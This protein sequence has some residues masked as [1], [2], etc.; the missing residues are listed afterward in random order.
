M[1]LRGVTNYGTG[2]SAHELT[3]EGDTFFR[4][5]ASIIGD[6][7]AFAYPGIPGH[8]R[9]QG[10]RFGNLYGNSRVGATAISHLERSPERLR[11]LLRR[12]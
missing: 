11:H 8:G 1:V 9:G 6:G 5:G 2:F 7:K 12:P 10:A 3:S 4:Y